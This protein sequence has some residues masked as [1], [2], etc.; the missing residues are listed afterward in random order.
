MV[1]GQTLCCPLSRQTWKLPKLGSRAEKSVPNNA[2]DFAKDTHVY[3]KLEQKQGKAVRSFPTNTSERKSRKAKS[4]IDGSS[5]ERDAEDPHQHGPDEVDEV[6]EI[7]PLRPA[8]RPSHP[9]TSRREVV[10]KLPLTR[11]G[12][13]P[14]NDPFSVY[15]IPADGS[16][17][18]AVDICTNNL[19]HFCPLS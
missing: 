14:R 5:G 17:P 1:Q 9:P 7:S 13:G 4:K 19:F 11:H 18:H 15:P 3:C 16:V 2:V 10:K 12:A 6:D 8:E